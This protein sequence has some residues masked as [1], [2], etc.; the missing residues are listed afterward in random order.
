[1]R[2]TDMTKKT[3]IE[4][5]DSDLLMIE[6]EEDTKSI[7]YGNLKQALLNDIP[8]N[9]DVKRMINNVLDKLIDNLENLKYDIKSHYVYTVWQSVFSNNVG[10][11][12]QYGILLALQYRYRDLEFKYL[13]KEEIE[14]LTDIATGESNTAV[15]FDIKVVLNEEVFSYNVYDIGSFSENFT[16]LATDD[17]IN[18]N[19]GYIM[20]MFNDLTNNQFAQLTY[21]SLELSLAGNENADFSFNVS[22]DM[23]VNNVEYQ[24]NI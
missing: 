16:E 9:N 10:N 24:E 20:V 23:F 5:E 12:I 2:L 11:N 18:D 15:D 7:T 17:L 22:E 4:V 3:S 14:D 8:N 1:M 6:D 19:A 21:N 13:T